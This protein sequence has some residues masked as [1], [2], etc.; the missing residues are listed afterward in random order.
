MDTNDVWYDTPLGVI[1]TE[2]E[3]NHI[4][5]PLDHD[6]TPYCENMTNETEYQECFGRFNYNSWHTNARSSQLVT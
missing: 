6:S 1:F 4:G 3:W 2:S 5:Y